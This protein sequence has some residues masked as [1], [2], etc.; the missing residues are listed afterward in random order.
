[1]NQMRQAVFAGAGWLS[2]LA[3]TLFLLSS[4]GGRSSSIRSTG[5]AEALRQAV[6]NLR[7]AE[8]PQKHY[9]TASQIVKCALEND[10]PDTALA[11]ASILTP[12]E[13]DAELSQVVLYY[14]KRGDFRR[15]RQN[16]R[17]IEHK[18]VH[19]VG[20][21]YIAIA[22]AKAGDSE[23]AMR[24]VAEIIEGADRIL[25]KDYSFILWPIFIYD[26]TRDAARA[27]IVQTLAEAGHYEKALQAAE[28]IDNQDQYHRAIASVIFAYAKAG[29]I[30]RAM[31]ILQ[32]IE[33][34]AQ[35]DNLIL[36]IARSLAREQQYDPALEIAQYAQ[37]STR[38]HALDAVA[39]EMCAQE[40]YDRAV[41]VAER[42]SVPDT[43]AY[44]LSDI[45][46]KLALK[47]EAVRAYQLYESIP[48]D[49]LHVSTQNHL[50]RWIATV[51]AQHGDADRALQIALPIS[52]ER[53]REETLATL[54]RIHIGA[55][56]PRQALA[57]A[58]HLTLPVNQHGIRAAVYI[59]TRQYA[60]AREALA[61]LL[62]Q[63]DAQPLW[64][65]EYLEYCVV[66]WGIMGQVDEA[67][68][69]L[70][71]A[72][73]TARFIPP[74]PSGVFFTHSPVQLEPTLIA[75]LFQQAGREIALHALNTL[76]AGAAF[77]PQTLLLL[78]QQGYHNELRQR[79]HAL[80]NPDQSLEMLA[81]AQ[82]KAGALD[83]AAD[84]AAQI[85]NS[86]QRNSLLQQVA[87]KHARAHA[88]DS[89]LRTTQTM[90][91][92]KY[93]AETLCLLAA[94]RIQQGEPNASVQ[95]L[96]QVAPL[97]RAV[98]EK[99]DILR[100]L[101]ALY[102]L[103]GQRPQAETLASNRNHAEERAWVYLGIAE[104]EL[105]RAPAYETLEWQQL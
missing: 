11:V 13:R 20:L 17:K 100:N 21:M 101:G 76:P 79:A 2:L 35:R 18:G 19:T 41:R 34:A 1:M 12:L 46:V 94:I 24:T 6:E 8:N 63:R 40:Q 28:R 52:Y 96:D 7:Q 78:A 51:L 9:Y 16:L 5:A 89:A 95:I 47:N 37:P 84:T 4:C 33:P 50:R 30:E 32:R 72:L 77:E 38:D 87:L 61:Q 90:D 102:T 43:R 15:A 97:L 85:K 54:C 75:V 49:S 55:N 42:I 3:M 31:E 88:H 80:N 26:N 99:D 48:M 68:R 56:R 70:E 73:E 23:A 59:R 98:S 36:N 67:R 93:R 71:Q 64:T 27:H 104:G 65:T 58:A 81:H 29:N 53:T 44:R 25:E 91:D 92:P 10:D 83:P 103:A 60:S 22:Q 39:S 45:A 105:G 82:I 74:L 69:T 62:Q 86:Y 66:Q 57:V 14:A